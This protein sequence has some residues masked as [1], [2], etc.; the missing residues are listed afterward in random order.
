MRKY[1][2]SQVESLH[3]CNKQIT[4]NGLTIQLKVTPTAQDGFMD[5]HEKACLNNNWV[6]GDDDGRPA[7]PREILIPI[8]RENM[9][10]PNRCLNT[11][12]MI[13]KCEELTFEGN[14]VELWRYYKRR[15]QDKARPCLFF[16]HGGGWIGGSVYTV[17]NA[18]KLVAE[19]ADAVVFNIEYS[20]AP[21]K[22]F[23]NGFNDCYYALKHVYDHAEEYGIDK[24]RITVA[25]DSA[26]GNL[27]AALALRAR[28]EKI[29]MISGQFLI[30]P[31]LVF[32]E[33]VPEGYNWTMDAYKMAEEDRP[34]IEP[35][36][37][38][39]RPGKVENDLMKGCYVKS[40]EEAQNPYISPMLAKSHENLPRTVIALAE[41]DG[42][43]LQGEFYGKQLEKAGVPVKVYR[44]TG[45]TH[46]FLDRL[47]FV[48][49]CEELCMEIAAFV[50]GE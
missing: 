49:Q 15:S 27:S 37:G 47:G 30:Y 23:P 41:F 35:M 43:R 26:G 13:T 33:T 6:A 22:P 19:M 8:I 14:K 17:E 28:D 2:M 40:E 45:M 4:E 38:L 24:E 20:L 44:Y 3:N 25:G 18:C 9:G 48:P 50:K 36:L 11:E 7:P 29:P 39:G 10:F 21:E 34:I 42:L 5:H 1:E 12:E 16:I 32:G 31:C 46:A